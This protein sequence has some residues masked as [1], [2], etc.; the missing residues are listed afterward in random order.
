MTF[1]L[2]AI[3]GYAILL[4][5]TDLKTTYS[6]VK[7]KETKAVTY[8]HPGIS[9]LGTFFAAA[10]I[11]PA[12]ALVL[13]LPAINVSGATKRATARGLQISIGNLGA[14]I[15]TQLYRT[16]DSPKYVVGHSVAMA[17]LF[18][19]ICVVGTIWI[20]LKRENA[21]K[22]AQGVSEKVEGEEWHGDD[23]VRWRFIT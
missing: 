16:E 8:R 10:G 22:E 2:I 4:G 7:G 20:V 15:G 6:V 3:I 5:N 17:Y 11:Y 9:Y 1:S 18:L 14:V 12:T 23:D 19:N 21:R 13:S